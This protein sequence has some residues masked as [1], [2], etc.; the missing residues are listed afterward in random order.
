MRMQQSVDTNAFAVQVFNKLRA[1]DDLRRNSLTIDSSLFEICQIISRNQ[2][3]LLNIATGLGKTL[4]VPP[5]VLGFFNLEKIII[6]EP[7]RILARES[8]IKLAQIYGYEMPNNFVTYRLKNDSLEYQQQAKI[9][10]RIDQSLLNEI[11]EHPDPNYLPSGIILIDEAHTN[12]LNN[13]LLLKLFKDRLPHNPATKLVLLSATPD[14]DLLKTTFNEPAIFHAF[15][16]NFEVTETLLHLK[17]YQHH[18]ERALEQVLVMLEN[19]SEGK[20][21]VND[22]IATEGTL[23]ALL[24]G[25]YDIKQTLSACAKRA[26]ELAISDRIELVECHSKADPEDFKLLSRAISNNKLRIIAGSS[27]PREGL[28]IE[29]VRWVVDSGQIKIDYCDQ[30]TGITE[31]QKI[32]VTKEH[33]TQALGRVGRQESGEYFLVTSTSEQKDLIQKPKPATLTSNLSSLLLN[34]AYLNQD[35]YNLDFPT[36]FNHSGLTETI[37]RLQ[38]QGLLDGTCK[39]TEL[40]KEIRK[41]EASP[42]TSLALFHANQL[43]V[44]DLVLIASAFFEKE[45]PIQVHFKHGSRVE[46]SKSAFCMDFKQVFSKL[47]RFNLNETANHCIIDIPSEPKNKNDLWRMLNGVLFER[48][49]SDTQSDFIAGINLLKEFRKCPKER[50]Q[51]WCKEYLLNFKQ[52]SEINEFCRNTK[53][54]FIK[55]HAIKNDKCNLNPSDVEERVHAALLMAYGHM[56]LTEKNEKYFGHGKQHPISISENSRC[57]KKIGS[58]AQRI[59][60]APFILSARLANYNTEETG[61]TTIR[62]IATFNSIISRDIIHKYLVNQCSPIPQPIYQYNFEQNCLDQ[63]FLYRFNGHEIKREFKRALYSNESA[64][65]LTQILLKYLIEEPG[66]LPKDL[67]I[68]LAH[69]QW[70]IDNLNIISQVWKYDAINGL[71]EPEQYFNFLAFKAPKS[72]SF[73]DYDLENLKLKGDDY[74]LAILAR[75]SKS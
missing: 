45:H 32:S 67:Q 66:I 72:L 64:N 27:L 36:E 71:V 7:K 16:Q 51:D 37:K 49:G 29:G 53:Q 52:L 12:S 47:K 23:L 58:G 8:A 28:N 46:L 44:F 5:A 42:E 73:V 69:N 24:P 59:E 11:I 39:I 63:Q 30:E 54:S 20:L 70:L 43:G 26:A 48:F 19:F 3:T 13:L 2:V 68:T 22:E 14:L 6:T 61:I 65:M 35:L 75:F 17:P 57:F 38:F 4:G 15:G 41:I 1:C 21:K 50:R 40:G 60:N 25:K 55:T 74:I 9:E 62:Q 34:L 33:I 18:S 31:L 10:F 56:L